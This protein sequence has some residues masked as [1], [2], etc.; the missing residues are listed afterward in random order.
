M[1]DGSGPFAEGLKARGIKWQTPEVSSVR[2]LAD[3]GVLETKP[4]LAHCIT[5][6]DDDLHLIKRANAGIAHCPKSN[7][8][9]GHGRAPFAKFVETEISVG[10][11]SDSVASNNACDILEEARFATLIARATHSDITV[12]AHHALFAAT[13]GGARALGL[14]DRI[15]ALREG[16][17]ADVAIFSLEGLHQQPVRDPVDVLIF[18]SSARDVLLTIVAGNEIYRANRVISADESDLQARLEHVGRK[19][20]EAV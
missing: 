18:S 17:Q 14:D 11:G 10:L 6:G 15:G 4:L 20:D 12:D 8:K 13:L 1:H 3:H 9:L 16:M 2:Y 7:A 5:V 19:L